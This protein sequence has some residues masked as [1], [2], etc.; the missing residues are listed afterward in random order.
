MKNILTRKRTIKNIILFFFFLLAVQHNILLAQ[1]KTNLEVFYSFTDSIANKISM[2]LDGELKE[3]KTKFILGEEYYI[4]ANRLTASLQKKT[5]TILPESS[6]SN[7]TLITLTIDQTKVEY[8]EIFRDGMFGE[9]KLERKLNLSGNYTLSGKSTKYFP[10]SFSSTDTV[11]LGTIQELE[12]ESFP[13]TKG[14]IPSEP[15][16][17]SIIEPAIVITTAA[18]SAILFFTI[19][20]K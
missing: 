1:A 11:A 6:T 7:F 5:I 2:N 16:L 9:L 8:G 4:F 15:F 3:V 18:V 10:F 14:S 17:S 12:T 19:R 13:F 20:S